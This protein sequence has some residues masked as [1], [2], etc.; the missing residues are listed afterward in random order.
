MRNR[1]Y[2]VVH[3]GVVLAGEAQLPRVMERPRSYCVV[4]VG[5][6]LERNR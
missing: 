3:V 6:V 5:V 4:P 2:G 1:S